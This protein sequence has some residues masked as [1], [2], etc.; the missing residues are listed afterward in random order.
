MVACGADEVVAWMKT[1]PAVNLTR[2]PPGSEPPCSA[3][4]L[5]HGR[6]AQTLMSARAG[7]DVPIHA[8]ACSA[9][10]CAGQRLSEAALTAPHGLVATR[11]V[12]MQDGWCCAL[13]CTALHC[14]V[15]SPISSQVS[16]CPRREGQGCTPGGVGRP[17]S[18]PGCA[19]GC[20]WGCAARRGSQGCHNRVRPSSAPRPRPA[21]Q[22]AA[23]TQKR[24]KGA[25]GSVSTGEAPAHGLGL[26]PES[27]PTH[28]THPHTPTHSPTHPPTHPRTHTPSLPSVRTCTGGRL[29][30]RPSQRR[31]PHPPRAV[32]AAAQPWDGSEC[33]AGP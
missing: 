20:A 5:K 3:E 31:P 11:G 30:G 14:A 28:P 7:A 12:G 27:T 33:V 15:R 18:S 25:P 6:D 2:S 1:S 13:R 8:P 9:D 19:V 16:P 32:E 23:C 22:R 26:S 4:T 21:E 17:G 24:A 29:P 10:T